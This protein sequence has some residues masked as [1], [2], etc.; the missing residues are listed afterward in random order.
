MVEGQIPKEAQRRLSTAEHGPNTV[1]I[2][3]LREVCTGEQ[4]FVEQVAL[5]H[6]GSSMS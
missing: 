5:Q 1:G 6:G 2:I 3:A 4:I